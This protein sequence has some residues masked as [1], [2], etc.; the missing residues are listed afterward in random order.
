MV[1]RVSKS[2]IST[3]AEHISFP[4]E[5]AKVRSV[6]IA[7]EEFGGYA[8]ANMIRG[9]GS[10]Q[11]LTGYIKRDDLFSEA[12]IQKL[13]QLT[14]LVDTMPITSLKTNCA[15]SPQ[16]RHRSTPIGCGTLC[17]MF[18]LCRPAL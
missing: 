11:A 16:F 2:S 8:P 7:L 3:E 10:A 12:G 9:E 14:G 18:S 13:N 17:G 15:A 6:L 4:A 5:A 1:L